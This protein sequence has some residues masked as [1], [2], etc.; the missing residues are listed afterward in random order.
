MVI[1]C[2]DKYNDSNYSK[3]F[4]LFPYELSDFQKY[5]IQGIVEGN[6]VL[7]TAHTGSGK[8]LPA[9]FAIRHFVSMGKKVI[10]T[11]PIK[12]LSNQKF[13]EFTIKYPEISF[14]LMTGDIK[15]NPDADVLIMT[16]EILMN[17][18]YSIGT[19]SEST[20]QF[21]I[22]IQNSLGCVIFDEVHYINDKDRGHVWEQTIL[23]LP[24]HIQMVLLSATIDNPFG[25]AEWIE[26]RA[27]LEESDK[28]DKPDK[29]DKP[30]KSV[31][32]ASTEHRV[33]PLTHYGFFTTTETPFKE[34]K[35][36]EIQKQ[37]RETSNKLILLRDPKGKFNDNGYYE[38]NRTRDLFMKHRFFMKRKFVLNTLVGF[39]KEKEML[40]AIIFVFSRKN[41]EL[42]ANEITTNLLEDDSK[43]PYIIRKE[44]QQI[45]RKF[46]NF[47]EY[48][49]LPEYNELVRLLEKGIGIHHSG[50]IPVLREIVELM[51]S[52]KYIKVLFATESFAIGLDCPIK[53]AVF[54]SLTKYDGS[55][56]RLLMPHEYTQM[57]GRAGRRGIDTIGNVVHCNN[58][59]ETPCIQDY[60]QILCG[61]PQKLVSKFK[62]SYSIVLNLLKNG[63]TAGF[64]EFVDKS[65][66]KKELDS[67]ISV[68]RR[69]VD[70]LNASYEKKTEILGLLR[71]PLSICKEYIETESSIMMYSSKKRKEIERKLNGFK[72]NYKWLLDDVMKIKE[73]ESLKKKMDFEISGLSYLE[74]YSK[75][76]IDKVCKILLKDEFI[77]KEEKEKEKEEK[78]EKEKYQLTEWG[79]IASNINEIHPLIASKMIMKWNWFENFNE[80]QII[81]LFSIFTDIHVPEDFK[82]LSSNENTCKYIKE[83]ADDYE[84][85][86]LEYELYTGIQYDKMIVYDLLEEMKG[87]IQCET[88]AECKYFIQNVII[89]R[90]ISIGDFSKA[91]LK[92]SVITKEFIGVCE[93]VGEVGLSLLHKLK[94]IDVL[95]LKY[96]ATPQSL[97]V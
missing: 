29:S 24:Q 11:S 81:A 31:Y 35:D 42:C 59:F 80:N 71:T 91:I 49:E 65:M 37:I 30:K 23:M 17:Y 88:A 55:T 38:I 61:K 15:T 12:A 85:R 5:A 92:I 18:L 97:Y 53:T 75:M 68:T 50:M 20:L 66:L 32:L 89:P 73:H 8:T 48:L 26:N 19:S 72:E 69:E 33:V 77:I 94:N 6:H 10:Y 13:Y 90:G 60:K 1:L 62:I 9:E 54:S 93:M 63:K 25:F 67:S 82:R 3:Y 64:H 83:L 14:G 28:P 39:L 43:I 78:E 27:C 86:E 84:K 7:I 74:N 45:I 40:P 16:T 57:A 79:L 76:N 56:M 96:I 46:P 87:W 52:K 95:I 58:L 21:Q 36:K 41:V 2:N 34:I 22:D 47:N 51:I 4:E 44:C 70:E